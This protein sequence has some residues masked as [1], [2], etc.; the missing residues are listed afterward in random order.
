MLDG[1]P[2]RLGRIQAVSSGITRCLGVG[3][4]RLPLREK[5]L[6]AWPLAMA[7]AGW[8]AELG[9]LRLASPIP[10]HGLAA[11]KG[12]NKLLEI[13]SGKRVWDLR[14]SH[15]YDLPT[16]PKRAGQ[17]WHRN[18]YFPALYPT[19]IEFIWEIQSLIQL[20]PEQG[21]LVGSCINHPLKVG[22]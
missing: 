1:A 12:W 11:V 20:I 4:R 16:R 6:P 17:Q 13:R 21:D 5:P 15:L 8:R 18:S 14:A 2:G 3:S 10:N 22:P 19:T 7:I 9:C